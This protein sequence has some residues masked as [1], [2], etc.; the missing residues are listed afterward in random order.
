MN[1]EDRSGPTLFQRITA[2]TGQIDRAV[3]NAVAAIPTPALD[4][5]MWALTSTTDHARLWIGV[6]GV[7]AIAGGPRGRRVAVRSMV[8][9]GVTSV[10]ANLVVKSGGSYVGASSYQHLSLAPWMH[11]CQQGTVTTTAHCRTPIGYIRQLLAQ[12][13][14]CTAGLLGSEGIPDDPGHI[15][16]RSCRRVSED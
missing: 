9:S 4:P 16:R 14:W 15:D 6:S 12:V 10:V 2:E 5:V 1:L 7:L 13:S 11:G 8:A 3:S